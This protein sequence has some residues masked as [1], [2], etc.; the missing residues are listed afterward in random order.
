[1]IFFRVPLRFSLH[2]RV[3]LFPPLY[4]FPFED[5]VEIRPNMY[6]KFRSIRKI[7]LC[8]SEKILNTSTRSYRCKHFFFEDLI[9]NQS[10]RLPFHSGVLIRNSHA[11]ENKSR[12][13]FKIFLPYLLEHNWAPL[14]Y[15]ELIDSRTI[16]SL[17]LELTGP[18]LRI[19]F[20]PSW[21]RDHLVLVS[22][23]FCVSQI[24]D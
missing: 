16:W 4:S 1:M 5:D 23:I 22:R 9:S 6:V 15:L 11:F 8:H 20:C 19:F 10:A 17:T 13:H 24:Q 7:I 3:Y 14:T 18:W 12:G 21:F 2:F